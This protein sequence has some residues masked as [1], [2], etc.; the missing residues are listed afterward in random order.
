MST[1]NKFNV[2]K[3]FA[4]IEHSA[5]SGVVG[6]DEYNV[7]G[8]VKL[9]VAT[10][11]TTSGTLTVQGRIKHSSTWQT[12]GTLT[13]GGDF[14]TFD[15]DGYDFIRFNFTVAAGSTGE[16]AASGFFKAAS[17][18]SAGAAASFTTIQADTGT[19]PVADSASDTL[20]LTSS[21]G[22][23]NVDGNST[24]DTIDFLLNRVFETGSVSE[25]TLALKA[26]ASQTARLLDAQDSSGTSL[27]G[28]ESDGTLTIRDTNSNIDRNIVRDGEADH[29]I[30][31]AGNSTNRETW[32]RS[33]NFNCSFNKN[34][35]THY[36]EKGW[37]RTNNRGTTSASMIAFRGDTN[38]GMYS[39][40]NDEF[41]LIAG[42]VEGFKN[43]TTE[44]EAKL[45]LKLASYATGSLPTASSFEGCIVYD[46][47]TQQVKYSDGSTWT[48]LWEDKWL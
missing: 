5:I 32:F 45:P 34:G 6:L 33:N 8:E 41:A 3:L 1:G 4:K 18:G 25:I 48:A 13:S 26:I 10:T 24:T 15:I 39:P 22:S 30:V 2:D 16:I 21:D 14:D 27:M 40:A 36:T 19:S 47:T 7:F 17:S 29:G 11:F 20:T 43:T 9:S 31:T 28:I 42:G 38:T 44:V 46:S 35:T 37:Y 12:I 23:I